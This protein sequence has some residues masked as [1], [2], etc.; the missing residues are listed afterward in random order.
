[1]DNS[2]FLIEVKDLKKYFTISHNLFRKSSK[3]SN[4]L[5]AVDGVSFKIVRGN[6]LGLA[7]ESGCGKTTTGKMLLKLYESNGGQYFFD[8]KNIANFR[9]KEEIK[10]FRKK[11]QLMFQN[12]F[13]AINPR[14]TIKRALMEPLIIYH[15]GT[16][17]EKEDLVK[18]ML[19]KV[20]LI[21]TEYYLDKYSHQ[22]S[23]GQLQRVI[24]ARALIVDPVFLV[25]DEPVSMLDVS[26][27]AGVLNLMKKISEEMKLTTVYISHDLSLIRYMCHEIAIMY[28]GKIVEIGQT[29]EVIENPRHPY[30]Q[31]LIEAV[32]IPDPEIKNEEI[33]IKNYVPSPIDLP[34]G[35]IFQNRCPIA[36]DICFKVEPKLR[37]I[38]EN[39]LVACH[40]KQK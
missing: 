17:K 34:P 28:L 31:A 13:E 18:Y 21:P 11:A 15:K 5:K 8:H 33:K 16:R 23:G 38:N 1:M 30:T 6:S 22:L 40:V 7:G 37:K 9:D 32:P 26:I 12:P 20:N 27:R 10:K 4:I 24:L 14:F 2:Q 36:T 35:C 19:N 39:H 25:A 29:D 3:K